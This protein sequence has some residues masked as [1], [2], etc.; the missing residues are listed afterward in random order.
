MGRV[1]TTFASKIH[2]MQQHLY[3]LSFFFLVLTTPCYS[4]KQPTPKILSALYGYDGCIGGVNNF[5]TEEEYLQELKRRN[6][7]V[8]EGPGG[9]EVTNVVSSIRLNLGCAQ[10]FNRLQ[11]LDGIPVTFSLPLS[12]TPSRTAFQV[13]LTDGSVSTPDCAVMAPANE[14][15]ELDTVLLLGRFGDGLG[16][17]VWPSRVEVVEE[18]LFAGLEGEVVKASSGLSFSSAEDLRYTASS[19]RMVYVR[20][21]DVN[22]FNEGT[23]YPT[24][25]LPS[26]TYPNNC[27]H[28]FPSTTHIVRVTFSGGVTRDGV[29]SLTPESTDIFSLH[30][31]QTG[32]Q[33][34]QLGLA[35]LG[36]TL[37]A[38][39]GQPYLQD[40]DNNID[41]CLDMGEMSGALQEDFVLT[42]H[43]EGESRLYP[44]KGKPFGCL[45]DQVLLTAEQG[46]GNFMKAW[47]YDSEDGAQYCPAAFSFQ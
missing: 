10:F 13:H 1:Q 28:L 42:L 30:T 7:T 39:A 14:A 9:T 18:L 29:T 45:P 38:P 4:A 20:M 17:T 21:W 22:Q 2:L 43:C 46:W 24:W 47:L 34:E 25:P 16:D 11:W 35:D 5:P 8:V 12:S 41:I 3:F 19:V 36:N 6:C 31:A 33:L 40:G 15:N 44:P 23:S 37:R 32:T 27:Q 26:S